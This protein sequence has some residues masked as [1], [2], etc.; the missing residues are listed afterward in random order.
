MVVIVSQRAGQAGLT[1]EEY[2]SETMTAAS[3]DSIGEIEEGIAGAFETARRL[4]EHAA[5]AIEDDDEIA[6]ERGRLV[7]IASPLRPGHAYSQPQQTQQ[8]TQATH[9]TPTAAR[10]QL[11]LDGHRIAQQSHCLPPSPRTPHAQHYQQRQRRQ[12]P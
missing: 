4:G 11:N 8:Q 9:P 3:L 2:E 6:S 12:K 10:R 7:P 5:A 1:G